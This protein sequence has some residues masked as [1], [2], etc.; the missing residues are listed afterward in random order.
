[1]DLAVRDNSLPGTTSGGGIR[2]GFVATLVLAAA[3]GVIFIGGFWVGS[4]MVS[5]RIAY[6]V[7]YRGLDLSGLG[8]G[9][10]EN[11]IQRDSRQPMSKNALV[12]VYDKDFLQIA[13]KDIDL[14]LDAAAVVANALRIGR[15][16]NLIA[17]AAEV[18]T[19][20]CQGRE[21]TPVV[22]YD[23]EKLAAKIAP[24][25][26]QI[27]RPVKDASLLLTD[28]GSIARGRASTGLKL[29]TDEWFESIEAELQT[30][31]YPRRLHLEP[32][33]AHPA[34]TDEDLAGIDTLM[35]SFSLSYN[36]N[37]PRGQAL[38]KAAR[39]L[40]Q[41]IFRRNTKLSFNG[42]MKEYFPGVNRGNYTGPEQHALDILA[43]CLYGSAL[44]GGFVIAQ[45]EA[46]DGDFGI[47]GV[48]AG[49]VAFAHG[50]DEDLVLKN[51]FDHNAYIVTYAKD[52]LLTVDILGASADLAGAQIELLVEQA[53]DPEDPEYGVTTVTRRYTHS[54]AE[55][56]RE[57]VAEDRMKKSAVGAATVIHE[58]LAAGAVPAVNGEPAS[59]IPATNEEPAAEEAAGEEPSVD[60]GS[61]ADE[62]P[63]ADEE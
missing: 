60:E 31:E 56:F 19:V 44:Y 10:A 33:E 16:S 46:G 13:P 1:M 14:Q 39:A 38:E 26:K 51:R 4:F 58:N 50:R 36:A 61:D 43:S 49:F 24:L 6:G 18:V 9:D 30:L 11:I 34:V 28:G 40:D 42:L 54:G 12:L 32:Q 5:D 52:G 37:S 2:L 22:T 55:L 41:K 25:E 57:L 35:G 17:N 3:L 21:V 23:R 63:A 47:E 29:S 45:R 8:A 7:T 20:A 53:D 59:E 48:P 15:D 27:R 62:E